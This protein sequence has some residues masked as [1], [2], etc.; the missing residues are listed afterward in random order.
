MLNNSDK[1]LNERLK[2]FKT[3]KDRDVDKERGF[4]EILNSPVFRNFVISEDGSTTFLIVYLKKGKDTANLNKK[5][6]EKYKDEAKKKNHENILE[7][8]EVIKNPIATLV[9]YF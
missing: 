3:L 8:R 6:L 1:P 5:D 7:I 9:K 2:N 4:S